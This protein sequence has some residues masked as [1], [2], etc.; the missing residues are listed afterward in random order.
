MSSENSSITATKETRFFRAKIDLY[1]RRA[2]E[3]LGM[4][5]FEKALDVIQLLEGLSTRNPAVAELRS[6]I[7]QV[8]SAVVH[9]TTNGDTTPPNGHHVR[10]NLLILLVDQDE[11]V[12]TS[13]THT[14]RLYGFRVMGA[15]TFE[16]ALR[17]LSL[18][19]PDVIISEVNFAD[20][21]IGFDLFFWVRNHSHLVDTPF[22]YLVSRITRE[23]LIAGKRFG[24]DDFI[25]KP[26]DPEV[27]VASLMNSL[28]LRKL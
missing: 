21:P 26:L 17:S 8:Q 24:V 7:E 12:L 16:E 3:Y 25:L 1:V 19:T 13:L 18:A 22:L 27:V 28:T 6:R 10:S 4:S 14:L 23:M 11:Q 9:G 2:E 20:G 5:R 15:G